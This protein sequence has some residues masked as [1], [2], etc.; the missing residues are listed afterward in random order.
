MKAGYLF[1]DILH[2]RSVL[3][4]RSFG[5]ASGEHSALMF[6]QRPA[7]D[8]E[9]MKKKDPPVHPIYPTA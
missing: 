5:G 3:V 9:V 2:P 1:A 6:H 7:R 4:L 8:R